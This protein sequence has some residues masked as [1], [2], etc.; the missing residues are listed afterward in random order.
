M[1]NLDNWD[2]GII[3]APAGSKFVG[4]TEDG[5]FIFKRLPTKSD[6]EDILFFAE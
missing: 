3:P 2:L 5:T 6:L 4:L 1:N